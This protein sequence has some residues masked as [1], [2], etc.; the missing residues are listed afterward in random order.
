[1]DVFKKRCTSQYVGVSYVKERSLFLSKVQINYKQI[2]IGFY[3]TEHAAALAYDNFVIKN[4]LNRRINF[5]TIPENSIP[6][7]RLV[8]LT[9]G[10]FAVVDED[11]YDEVMQYKWSVYIGN[12]VCY[13]TRGLIVDGI[14]TTQK[15]HRFVMGYDSLD[16]DHIDGNGLHN[17]RSN[18]RYCTHNENMMNKNSYKNTS[19]KYKGVTF[20]KSVGKYQSRICVNKKPMHIGMFKTEIEAAMAYNRKAKELFGSFA[21]FNIVE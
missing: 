12:G 19:S 6:N 11:M 15:M 16:I 7:T 4:S 8:P 10:Y 13:A 2:P 20:R 21:R 5:F 18:L 17:Y 1:M 14:K 3:E 9:R